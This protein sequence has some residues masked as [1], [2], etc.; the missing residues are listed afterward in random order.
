MS[1]IQS[2][3]SYI[4]IGPFKLK[5]IKLTDIKPLV[6]KRIGRNL[7]D[8]ARKIKKLKHEK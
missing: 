6:L 4:T 7:V 2:K 1:T 5:Y 8:A 3:I